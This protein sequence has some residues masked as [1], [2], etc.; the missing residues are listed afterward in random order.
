MRLPFRRSAVTETTDAARAQPPLERK[1]FDPDIPEGGTTADQSSASQALSRREDVDD[2]YACYMGCAPV[3][4]GI[5]A[6][7]RTITAGGLELVPDDES[8]EK[9]VK[10]A[11]K[12]SPQAQAVS[13]LIAYVNPD[14]DI[15]QLLRNA[16][17]DLLV[18]GDAF[19]ELTWRYGVPA[20]I[21][22]LDSATTVPIADPH[23][24]I[25]GYV[26]TVGPGRV[27]N[28]EPR[29]VVHIKFDAP[30]GGV[31]GTSPVR[32]AMAPILTWI[33]AASLLKATMKKGNPPRLVLD[34]PVTEDAGSIKR[35]RQQFA[36]RH[37]G[38]EN[39]G[40]PVTTKGKVGVT[41]LKASAIAEYLTTLQDMRDVILSELGVPGRKVGV[42][43]P[44]SLGGE[45][46][47]VGQDRTYKIDTCRPTGALVLEKLNFALLGAFGV[48][49]FKLHW[50]EQDERNDIE[51]ED[52]RD[53]RLR[54]GSWTLNRYRADI[55]EPPVEGGD[56][57]VIIDRTNLVAWRDIPALVKAMQRA[58][59]AADDDDAQGQ[60]GNGNA[61]SSKGAKA[62]GKKGDV[63]PVP[64]TAGGAEAAGD[65]IDWEAYARR[66]R[67]ARETVRDLLRERVAA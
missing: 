16:I 55:G 31:F 38:P 7:A 6:I 45:G 43:E 65:E 5:D 12:L 24:T 1:G 40:I 59:A 60:D 11:T 49:G 67:M 22:N 37:L 19:L 26:Q 41:E 46:V 27:A 62:N 56:E 25:T 64:P 23:G 63:A 2:L 51:E 15:V 8:P 21:W 30:R 52:I 14:Q 17:V 33:W 61:G 39:L 4:T 54:N 48:K 47:E 9:L 35:F 32:K 10:A 29:E 3:S 28:F 42:S 13:D 18:T 53:N 66:Q 58:P 50:G 34:F 44:G 36:P 20:A 57:P